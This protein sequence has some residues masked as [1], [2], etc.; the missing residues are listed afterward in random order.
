MRA[1]LTSDE[2]ESDGWVIPQNVSSPDVYLLELIAKCIFETF[3]G[4][5]LVAE[6]FRAGKEGYRNSLRLQVL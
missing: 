5:S 3:C 2:I 6:E 1:I 4:M